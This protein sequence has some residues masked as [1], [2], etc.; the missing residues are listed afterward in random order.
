M[1]DH[2]LDVVVLF[3]ERTRQFDDHIVVGDHAEPV[4]VSLVFFAFTLGDDQDVLVSDAGEAEGEVSLDACP[5]LAALPSSRRPPSAPYSRTLS[6]PDSAPFMTASS[7]PLIWSSRSI[8]SSNG[9][10]AS[11][12]G[13]CAPARSARVAAIPPIPAALARRRSATAA[14]WMARR[15]AISTLPHCTGYFSW[16]RSITSRGSRLSRGPRS[17]PLDIQFGERA[18]P[19]PERVEGSNPDRTLF[20]LGLPDQPVGQ[21]LVPGAGSGG[22]LGLEHGVISSAALEAERPGRVRL[23]LDIY[24]ARE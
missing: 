17:S 14:I 2:P 16:I 13:P 23:R 10:S 20:D 5:D 15:L 6:R 19:T 22:V 12:A 3:A 11:A 24:L 4:G 7:R 21:H 9:S 18:G 1:L 8:C